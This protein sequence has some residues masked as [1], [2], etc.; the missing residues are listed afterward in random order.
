MIDEPADARHARLIALLRERSVRTGR[1]VLASGAVSDLYVDVR[2]TSLHQEGAYLIGRAILERLQPRVVGVGGMTLGADPIACSAAALGLVYD[3]PVHAFLVRK[4]AKA[5]GTAG[6]VE[7]LANLPP[8]SPVAVVEDTTTT[9]S[10]LW[11]AIERARSAGL[12]VVQ[13]ITV[14]DR[15]EG[16]VARLADLGVRL[17]SLTTRR[18]L[19]P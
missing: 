4:E 10:S 1:F 5:H 8:G 2:Q 7:G 16:A 17:E 15:E 19:C 9:G 6:A 13:A 12:D 11:A 18:D 14:V 3:R